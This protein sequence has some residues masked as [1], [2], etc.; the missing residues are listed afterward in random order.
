MLSRPSSPTWRHV[1]NYGG[2]GCWAVAEFA[3]PHGMD[4]DLAVTI[5]NELATLIDSAVAAP[6][7]AEI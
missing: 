4:G 7:G 6:V 3:D 2:F 1:Y 5:A